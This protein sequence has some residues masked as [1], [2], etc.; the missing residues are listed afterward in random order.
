MTSGHQMMAWACNLQRCKPPN[1]IFWSNTVT[2]LLIASSVRNIKFIAYYFTRLFCIK[3]LM[4][5][6][7]V[8]SAT[9]KLGS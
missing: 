8:V 5:L 1:L 9:G 7:N 4:K 3:K 6:N 2:S